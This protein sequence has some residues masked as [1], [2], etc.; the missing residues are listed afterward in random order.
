MRRLASR[1]RFPGRSIAVTVARISDG[2][3]ATALESWPRLIWRMR[4]LSIVYARDATK[5]NEIGSIEEWGGP[6][7][8]A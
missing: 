7:Q 5:C 1:R 2:E 4:D 6:T 8:A 3:A